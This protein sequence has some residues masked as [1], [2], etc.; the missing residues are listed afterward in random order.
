MQFAEIRR[1]GWQVTELEPG[2]EEIPISIEC[3]QVGRNSS[4][5]LKECGKSIMQNFQN[6][7]KKK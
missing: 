5:L 3:R 1:F 2:E 4:Y 7:M 6:G